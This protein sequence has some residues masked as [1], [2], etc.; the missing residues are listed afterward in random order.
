MKYFR[1]SRPCTTRSGRYDTRY[2][3]ILR[4]YDYVQVL[5]DFFLAHWQDIRNSESMKTVWKQIRNGRH[6]GFEE[7]RYSVMVSNQV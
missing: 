5:V 7:G 1:H 3:L 4:A 2:C 6:P